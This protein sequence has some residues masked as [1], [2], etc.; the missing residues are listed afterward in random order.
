MD[1]IALRVE[2]DKSQLISLQADIEKLKKGSKID[3]K[4]DSKELKGYA[5]YA[6]KAAKALDNLAKA[7]KSE[8]E[9]AKQAAATKKEISEKSD[10]AT[11]SVERLEEGFAKLGER[12]AKFAVQAIVTQLREAVTELKNVDT[13]LVTIQKVTGATGEEMDAFAEKAYEAAA[14]L[15]V[16][17]S[18]YL[19]SVA[20]FAKAGYGDK[21]YELGELATMTSKVG[22]TSQTV[23]NQFL[24]SV[25]AAYKYKGSITEL[26]KVLD[27]ANQIGNEYATSVEKMASG[28]GKVAPI[29]S[30]AHVGIDELTAAIGTIT[31]VTQR[32]GEE[33]STALRALFLN[34]IGDTKTEIDEGVTWTTGEIAGLQ[35]VLRTY[36]PE[37]VAAAEATGQMINPME[38]IGALAQS[39]KDG[40][41]T[42]QEL[43]SM[44]SDIGGKLRTSQLLALIQNWDMYENMLQTY[45]TSAGSAAEEYAIYMDSWEARTAKLDATWT[46]FMSH[47]ANSGAIKTVITFI[48]DLI[49]VLD[50]LPTR[51]FLVTTAVTTAATAITGFIN[52]KIVPYINDIKNALGTLK[53]SFSEVAQEGKTLKEAF[54]A[55]PT[56]FI[57]GIVG[58]IGLI[59]TAITLI[60]QLCDILTV[61][62]EEQAEITAKY[63]AQLD[64][65][66]S[67]YDALL[68]KGDELTA[69]ERIR[70]GLLEKEKEILEEQV[71]L[72]SLE[73]LEKRYGTGEAYTEYSTEA[74]SSEEELW[75]E[76][77]GI[78]VYKPTATVETYE[79]ME[80]L[81]ELNRKLADPTVAQ[82]IEEQNDLLQD[83]ADL[84]T[85]LNSETQ[86]L[87]EKWELLGND[88]PEYARE[89]LA[90]MLSS[91]EISGQKMTSSLYE[92][93]Q[94]QRGE[95]RRDIENSREYKRL[96]G[97]ETGNMELLKE[98]LRD[99]VSEYIAQGKSIEHLLTSDTYYQELTAEINRLAAGQ[100]KF[101]EAAAQ[102]A[103]EIMSLNDELSEATSNIEKYRAA[104]EEP[105]KGDTFADYAEIYNT[106][107]LENWEKGL[108]GSNAYKA[109]VEA[110]L[111]DDV[112]RSIEYDWIAAGEMLAS[113]FWK[114]VFAENGEDYGASFVASLKQI[115]DENGDIIDDITGKAVAHFEE[116]D[117]QVQMSVDSFS[118]LAD[119]LGMDE[120]VIISIMDALDI[121]APDL[122]TSAENMKQLAGECGA[123][124]VAAN[125]LETIDLSTFVEGL[126]GNGMSESQIWD[127]VK[128]AEQLGLVDLSS[129]EGELSDIIAAAMHVQVETEAATGDMEE[130]DDQTAEPTVTMNTTQFENRYS[131]V[132][133]VLDSLD[134]RSVSVKIDT[135]TTAA[136][137][138][139]DDATGGDTLV[140]EEG[141]ELIQEGNRARIAGGGLP[142]ITKLEPHAKVFTAEETKKILAGR[143][144]TDYIKAAAGGTT[145]GTVGVP[146]GIINGGSTY[147]SGT[148]SNGNSAAAASSA[149][150]ELSEAQEQEIE[151]L[152]SI[153]SLRQKEL[154]LMEKQGRPIEERNAKAEEIKDALHAQ[155]EYMRQVGAEQEEILDVSIDW[156]N[157]EES[158]RQA[159][160]DAYE[161]RIDL[162]E[163]EIELME[164]Q[165]GQV[166]ERISKLRTIQSLLH[167]EAEYLRSIGAAQA[168]INKLS[169]EWW[170]IEDE[171]ADVQQDL[172][173]ELDEAIQ[174]QLKD[175]RKARDD[176]ID[177][178]DKQIES[179]KA[180]REAK[181][182]E[183]TLE[184][185]ILAVEEARAN[186]ANAQNERNIRIYNAAS[187]Q[188]EWVANQ[189]DVKSAEEALKDAEADL[190]DYKDELEF[191]AQID[192]M[193][194]RK[195]ALNNAYDELEAEWENITD[196]IQ[197]PARDIALILND[198]AQ[199]GTPEMRAQINNIKGL[200][201]DLANYIGAAIGEETGDSYL[202]GDGLPQK[203]YSTD[204]TDYS[205]LALKSKSQAEFDYWIAQRNAKI[206]AQGIDVK[207]EGY[208]TNAELAKETG[209]LYD[210]GGI[211]KG[212]G[213]IKATAADE[214][215]LPPEITRKMLEPTTD[216]V[217]KQ[218]MEELN[219][220]YGDCTSANA[221]GR[222]NGGNY[223]DH[224]GDEYHFGDITLNEQQAKSMTVYD[225][226]QM[227]RSL[228]IRNAM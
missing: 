196:S 209:F 17:A 204:S 219:V 43:M 133:R 48:T 165:G 139:T 52:K 194:A 103:K 179:L 28:L 164:N 109:A 8:A 218:R 140:N 22:D 10:E 60:V 83:R 27:G 46:E 222:A 202:G 143:T 128:A 155:A 132:K 157:Q 131:R 19:E 65:V 85:E 51:W 63:Q 214:M 150:A 38:A 111:P 102:S 121:F 162:L 108:T 39:M 81:A 110:L 32:T 182:D 176:E 185:K 49:R 163:T 225:L 50:N 53:T 198:I 168:D 96:L 147:K 129:T 124:Y 175:A 76:Q 200:L 16:T 98:A 206:A 207:A 25:D 100:A 181:Q 197:K 149:A 57:G 135:G 21:A 86:W 188:W 1:I 82:S 221:K 79:K 203:D 80:E 88:M 158:R 137:E 224:S 161:D 199:N 138:G 159:I 119:Y 73:E 68:Q 123:L 142:T 18:T 126:A 227:S 61:T 4:V 173:D 192:A 169:N 12:M 7:E 201:G 118:E 223:T 90:D 59:S 94:T 184:E 116:I 106:G 69:Q 75:Y 153:V 112:L 146:L 3:V 228:G 178:I 56:G 71:K 35:D 212:L 92:F 105:E 217:F 151:R 215:I 77:A 13:A 180:A 136:A 114:A 210:S 220:L 193:E 208:R 113:D 31:A 55:N 186:L 14:K 130:L 183:L 205:A 171:I 122:L 67:E 93:I 47:I 5:E 26:T 167:S 148:G 15:G 101:S 42:E 160:T 74:A 44:V 154:E 24:L 97:E 54:K 104:L 58:S 190:A 37:V 72:S 99:Y 166:T 91:E 125:G 6:K 95:T 156:W 115:A 170:K 127:I 2:V 172:W 213:G 134:G 40:L 145:G 23:A 189:A 211:L 195:E 66:N 174:A 191:N 187:G 89:L 144:M 177:A 87:Y 216:A 30:Q 41:L 84:L 141:P 36:A 152:K 62:W 78:T 20:E 70:L 45:A 9:A 64:E 11:K 226:A 33:A 107:F 29:A 34:I 120:G 117:G